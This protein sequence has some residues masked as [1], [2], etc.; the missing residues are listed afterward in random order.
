MNLQMSIRTAI[1]FI[2]LVVPVFLALTSCQPSPPH[3]RSKTTASDM[4]V[5]KVLVSPKVNDSS[6]QQA[7]SVTATPW[8][9]NLEHAKLVDLTHSLD[10]NTIYWPT[11]EDFK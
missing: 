1:V 5:Q 6:Q 8:F 10:A 4:P 11:E 2:A 9:A 3:G 7:T